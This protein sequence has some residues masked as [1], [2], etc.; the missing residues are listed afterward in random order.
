MSVMEFSRAEHSALLRA[1]KTTAGDDTKH[2]SLFVPV[3][4]K[5]YLARKHWGR[6]EVL[7]VHVAS[8][9]ATMVRH[10][11]RKPLQIHSL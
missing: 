5:T 8:L 9:V 11:E 7:E 10:V 3:V 6:E 1:R 2:F 4:I